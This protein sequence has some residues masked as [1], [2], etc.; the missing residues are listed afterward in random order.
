MVCPSLVQARRLI[1]KSVR[2]N[3]RGKMEWQSSGDGERELT[4]FPIVL[5]GSETPVLPSDLRAA[6][7][8]RR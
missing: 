2:G 3:E 5:A 1:I 7:V 4:I 6:F 8:M